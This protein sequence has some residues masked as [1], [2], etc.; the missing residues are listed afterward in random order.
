M[1]DVMGEFWPRPGQPGIFYDEDGC[2][3]WLACPF[4]GFEDYAQG[5]GDK[6]DACEKVLP[7][8]T[9]VARMTEAGR[10]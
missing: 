6:C 4:C 7:S 8:A 9:R 10:E 2:D 5:C 1:T 3:H